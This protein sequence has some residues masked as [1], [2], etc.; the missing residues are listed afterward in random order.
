MFLKE[1][2][3]YGGGEFVFKDGDPEI[4]TWFLTHSNADAVFHATFVPEPATLILLGLGFAG[5]AGVA[6]SG[7]CRS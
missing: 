5:L 7:R 2:N 6:G 3:P 1:N 4:G